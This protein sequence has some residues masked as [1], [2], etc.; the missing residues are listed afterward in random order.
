MSFVSAFAN[1]VDLEGGYQCDPDDSGNWTGGKIGAGELKGTKYGISAASYPDL[2]IK[3]LTVQQAEDIYLRD[4]WKPLNL[5]RVTNERIQEEIFDTGVNCGIGSAGKIAQRA[6][7]F[8]EPGPIDSPLKV[9]GDIGPVTLSYLNKWCSKDPEALFKA[10]NGEQYC[11]YK[12]CEYADPIKKKYGHAWMQRI[13]A[14][15]TGG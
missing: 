7:N 15:R 4:F 5:D 8:L 13:Q 14:Y 2:D 11:Y 6:I 10:L 12:E 1:T 3:N 9:D